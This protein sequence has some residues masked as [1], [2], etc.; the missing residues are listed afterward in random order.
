MDFS[1]NHDRDGF[2]NAFAFNIH[3]E[4]ENGANSAEI[5]VCIDNFIDSRTELALEI[6][7]NALE[8]LKRAVAQLEKEI[9]G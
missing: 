9:A 5:G 6:R 8:F 7:K 3:E 2:N 4:V 1:T